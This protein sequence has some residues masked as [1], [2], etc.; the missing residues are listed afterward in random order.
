M[1]AA[2]DG[3]EGDHW[4]AHADRYEAT[5]VAFDEKLM[6]ALDIHQRS[7]VLDVGCGTG[8]MTLQ[9]G[10]LASEG[11]VLGVDLSSQMLAIARARAAEQG[12]ERVEFEQADAQV[13]R[14]EP[15]SFDLVVSNCGAMFFADPVAAFSNLLRALRPHGSIALLVWRDLVR[16][17]WVSAFREAL[18]AGR[19]LPVPPPG[20]QGPFSMADRAIATERL[21]A[22]GFTNLRFESIDEPV[23]FGRDVDDAYAFV[24]TFG[25]ARGLTASLDDVT[26]GSAFEQ[27]RR[28]LAAHET[29][30]GVQYAG[31]AWLITAA[32]EPAS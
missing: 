12:L 16:N 10:R 26:R 2:W 13:H 30:A 19:D 9:I 28:S 6:A 24:S 1:A 31:S 20:G 23:Y 15:A 3:P 29:D 22:A 21:E 32:A 4:A 7:A 18:A 8:A 14:F 17:E 27:L 25:I 11:A 5:G